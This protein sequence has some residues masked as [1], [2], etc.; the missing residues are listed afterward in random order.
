MDSARLAPHS[1]A[2]SNP[3]SVQDC[4]EHPLENAQTQ[5]FDCGADATAAAYSQLLAG[6]QAPP[7]EEPRAA[8]T[9]VKQAPDHQH[10]APAQDQPQA[11]K[12]AP[13]EPHPVFER[14]LY[15]KTKVLAGSNGGAGGRSSQPKH[16]GK[17]RK[18]FWLFPFPARELSQDEKE[19]ADLL[20][21]FGFSQPGGVRAGRRLP[22]AFEFV[23]DF[24]AG[25]RAEQLR[26]FGFALANNARAG[27]FENAYNGAGQRYFFGVAFGDFEH[28]GRAELESGQSLLLLESRFPF[29]SFFEPLLALLFNLVRLKRLELFAEHF[30]GHE[31][32]P[33]HL[34]H[35]RKFDCS[36]VPKVRLAD[37]ILTAVAA[38]LLAA[39]QAQ[40]FETGVRLTDPCLGQALAFRPQPVLA[41]YYEALES[42]LG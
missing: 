38:P 8:T 18:S 35:L 16:P 9:P 14:L 11:S 7:D 20:T 28:L 10:Q 29:R 24:F 15:C 31:R 39:L 6:R 40:S 12:K 25:F 21:T 17:L 23:S 33:G 41:E 2:L 32:D 27:A 5:T 26:H 36:A 3:K 22:G 30:H 42:S 13:N 1:H 37:Q 19:E 4:T 34:E